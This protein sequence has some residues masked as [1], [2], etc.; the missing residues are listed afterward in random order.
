[1]L[2]A[3]LVLA[4]P[5]WSSA[6]SQEVVFAE[7]ITLQAAPSQLW[8]HQCRPSTSIET[9]L[10]CDQSSQLRSFDFSIT[11]ELAQAQL[12]ALRLLAISQIAGYHFKQLR[13]AHLVKVNFKI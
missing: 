9:S 1:M 4:L 6:Q 10:F 7:D 3:Y 8:S 12:M 13:Y 11:S 5:L 2:I